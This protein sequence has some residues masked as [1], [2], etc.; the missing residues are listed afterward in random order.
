MNFYSHH[1][2]D[3]IRDTSRLNDSQC[4][5][6]LRMLWIYY[7]S[8]EPLADDVPALAFRIGAIEQDVKQILS[9]F[10][11]MHDGRWH[12]SRCDEEILRFREKSSKA[13]VSAEKRWKNA[14]A[15]RT[16]KQVAI[17]EENA[18][19]CERMQMHDFDPLPDQKTISENTKSMRTHSERNANEP[20]FDANQEPITNNQL[21]NK[22]NMSTCVDVASVFDHWRERMG[23][24]KAKLD[25]KRKKLIRSALKTGYT[26]DDLIEAIDGCAKSPFHMGNNDRGSVFDGLDLILRSASKIDSF[27]KLNRTTVAGGDYANHNRPAREDNSAA[28]RVRA[29]IARERAAEAA[30]AQRNPSAVADDVI[31]V[32]PQMDL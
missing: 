7:E 14:N 21:N 20:L 26:K 11:F 5:A 2:G 12:Q 29:A 27:I 17:D 13:K 30:S 16:H 28:G 22:N 10:F 15:M 23:H 18:N 4:M 8:E 6:Y 9:H 25:E 24:T 3:F 32:W 19:A 1:I 31:D